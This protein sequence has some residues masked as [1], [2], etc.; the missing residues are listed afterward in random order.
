MKKDRWLI[1]ALIITMIAS[2]ARMGQPDGGWYDD[3]PPSVVAT[4]PADKGTKVKNGVYFA[5]IKAKGADGIEYNIKRDVNI[6]TDY[7]ENA[8]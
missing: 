8:E 7:I 4:S 2:C 5:L 1:I 3:T 6:L